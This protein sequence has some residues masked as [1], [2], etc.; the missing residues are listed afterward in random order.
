[1]AILMATWL[2]PQHSDRPTTVAMASASSG[3][4]FAEGCTKIAVRNRGAFQCWRQCEHIPVISITGLFGV[5][6]AA[7]QDA[8]SESAAAP[9]GASPTAPHCSQIRNTT[10]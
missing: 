2:K 10:G 6:P 3:R 1:M 8:L 5:N 4:E 7:R 9:P